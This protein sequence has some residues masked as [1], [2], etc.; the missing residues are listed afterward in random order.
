MVGCHTAIG[1]FGSKG[2]FAV[3]VNARKKHKF[4][5]G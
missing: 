3:V 2:L 1:R 5:W 4:G